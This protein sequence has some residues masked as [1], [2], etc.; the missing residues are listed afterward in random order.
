MN[1]CFFL[2]K[3]LR[4]PVKPCYTVNVA[5]WVIYLDSATAQMRLRSLLWQHL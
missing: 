1:F 5:I 2:A 4:F 3:V